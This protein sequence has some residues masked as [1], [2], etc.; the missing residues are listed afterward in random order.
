M[1]VGDDFHTPRHL[2]RLTRR[3]LLTSPI[4][5]NASNLST[6]AAGLPETGRGRSA[7]SPLSPSH[8]LQYTAA[9]SGRPASSSS[10]EPPASDAQTEQ[11][12]AGDPGSRNPG[13]A[14]SRP[15][16][17]L[18]PSV[19][20]EGLPTAVQRAQGGGVSAGG[21]GVGGEGSGGWERH[22]SV[23]SSARAPP[24]L[25][26]SPSLSLAV[27]RPLPRPAARPTRPRRSL[28]SGR[29]AES[30][31]RQSEERQEDTQRMETRGQRRG[32]LRWCA[33]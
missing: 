30:S 7:L 11:T 32:G 27:T 12:S 22:R 16:A 15:A 20:G 17:R 24:S 1:V 5:T 29:D 8:T 25:S 19:A 26:L 9:F 6:G 31:E 3:D 23:V 28:P 4:P 14:L 18:Q 21:K 2:P 10:R 33:A 13:T